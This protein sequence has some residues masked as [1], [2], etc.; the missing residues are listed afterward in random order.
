P[1]ANS[2]SKAKEPPKCPNCGSNDTIHQWKTCKG[3]QK[4]INNVEQDSKQQEE[5]TNED[6]EPEMEFVE[7]TD[8]QKES[9]EE[10]ITEIG[11]IEAIPQSDKEIAHLEAEAEVPYA[12]NKTN[13]SKHTTDA[14]LLLTRPSKGKAHRVGHQNITTIIVNDIEARLL[15]DTGATCSVVGS[16]YLSRILPDWRKNLIDCSHMNFSGCAAALVPIG[17]LSQQVIFPHALGNVRILPEFVVMDNMKSQYFILGT[18]FLSIYG[19]NVYNGREHYFTI[20]DNQH[21]KFAILMKNTMMTVKNAT[22]ENENKTINEDSNSSEA[23]FG[24]KLSQEQTL[25]VKKSINQYSNQFDLG[26]NNLG[27]IRNHPVHVALD[28]KKPYPPILK[29]NAYPASPRNRVEIEKHIDEL[30]KMNIIR[31]LGEDEI[32]DITTPVIIAWHNGKSRL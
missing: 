20:N 13:M 14:K 23:K 30:L 26:N 21:K 12:G 8:S 10:S 9:D 11:A 17:V 31:K 2:N 25:A 3:K 29:K 22:A 19:I 5:H 27:K 6:T 24:P 32:V 28:V 18:E 1:Q 15:L 4:A 7:Y 16:D